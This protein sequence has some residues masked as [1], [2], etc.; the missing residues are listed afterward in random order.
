MRV[1]VTRMTDMAYKDR[2]SLPSAGDTRAL[3]RLIAWMSPAFPVGAFSYS[4]GL[5]QAVADGGVSDAA[6][7]QDWLSG[8]LAGGTSW[9]DAVL[10]AESYRAAGDAARLHAVAALAEAMAG[11]RERQMETMLQGEAF[12]A[13]AS[14]WSSGLSHLRREREAASCP[15]GPD[16]QDHK[17]FHEPQKSGQV[18]DDP[19]TGRVA[20]PV[21][22]G[23]VAGAHAT[24]IEPAIAAYLHAAM[25]NQVSVAI[26]CGVLGQRAGV[27]V[28][29]ALEEEI[30]EAAEAAAA[31]S[32]DDLGSAGILADIAGI[33]HETLT[34]RLFRS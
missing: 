32:L 10:L 8:A 7:L 20:Y 29:A 5:E 24:G 16:D 4:S 31:S 27:A 11:S 2:A 30:A 28:I 12:V 21:A 34:S 33:R 13:A 19:M 3:L 23:A 17:P 18:P 26:R 25:S 9:N 6:S 22:V 15:D 1:T 14:A